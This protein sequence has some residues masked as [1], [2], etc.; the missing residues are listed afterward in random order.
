MRGR[1]AGDAAWPRARRGSRVRGACRSADC[2]TTT[3]SPTC[4]PARRAGRRRRVW[5][6][7][8]THI[9]HNDPDGVRGRPAGDPRGARRRRPA[10]RRC[11]FADARARRLP[12]RP[13]TRCSR[14]VRRVRR[15]GSSRCAASTPTPP[16]RWTRRAAASR[17]A[18]AGFK[19]HPR[20]D[21]FGLPHPV[22]ERARRA[23]RRAPAARALPRRARHPDARRDASSHLARE[24]PG[25]RLI[26]AHAGISDL[27][28]LG[29][30]RGRAPEPPVRH[31]R[32]GRSPT[33]STLF[34][35]VPPGQILYASDMPYGGRRC[36]RVPAAL[37]ARRRAW[38]PRQR[39]AM[40]GAPARA[41]RRRRGSARPRARARHRRA[42]GRAS[43]AG[44]RDR[45]PDRAR[46]RSPSAA[47]TPPSRSRWPAWAARLPRAPSTPTLLAATD[48]LLA[49]A[50]ERRARRR[51]RRVRAA[52]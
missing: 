47:A 44:A 29:A 20:S 52:P 51:A 9:G 33:C 31:R 50:E 36:G 35:T 26:L 39:A 6:D 16:A 30:A 28:L 4:A 48:R 37:R 19:L 23:G 2:P 25:A 13:T 34:T 42:S 32:G 11:V 27:G 1:A 40:A 45:L 41:R 43:S 10:A 8:H 7:A 21:A 49:L 3:S 22:V 5:F 24:H 46:C 17:P 14:A 15:A 38:R 18:R 12:R